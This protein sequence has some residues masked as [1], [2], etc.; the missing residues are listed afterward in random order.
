MIEAALAE[1]GANGLR[2][3]QNVVLGLPIDDANKKPFV[4][5][6][7]NANPN[8]ISFAVGNCVPND[9]LRGKSPKFQVYEVTSG[10]AAV[11]GDALTSGEPVGIDKTATID[12][13]RSSG[14]RY[15]KIKIVFE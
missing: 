4:A 15:F 1:K 10:G 7:Q 5:P 14:V 6:V 13:S 2:N 9:N 8:E 12:L 11:Y 3:W